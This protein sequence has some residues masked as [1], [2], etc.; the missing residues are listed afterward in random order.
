M[1]RPRPEIAGPPPAAAGARA[2]H[3]PDRARRRSRWRIFRER[4]PSSGTAN[5]STSQRRTASAS[6]PAD[7]RRPPVS[8]KSRRRAR[9]SRVSI[10]TSSFAPLAGTSRNRRWCS[11][12]RMLASNSPSRRRDLAQNAG[13]IGNGQAERDDAVVALQFAHHDRGEDPRIDVAAAQDQPDLAAAK[14][15]AARPAWRQAPPRPRLPPW[16]SASVRKALTARS[17]SGS[18]TSTMSRTSSR[19]TGSVSVP[20]F[21]TAMPSASVGPPQG[22]CAVVKRVPHRRIKRGLDADD[23]D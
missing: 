23:L 18:S 3:R 17:I 4:V 7:S 9:A 2:R 16:F 8:G 5:C 6:R 15:L 11:T 22:R 10:V 21:F 14:A 12:P 20:T 1:P 19:T 13:P